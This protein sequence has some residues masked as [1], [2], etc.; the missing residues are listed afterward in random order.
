MHIG[1][2]FPVLCFVL[3]GLNA[4]LWLLAPALRAG[5]SALFERPPPGRHAQVTFGVQELLVFFDPWLALGLFPL[6][7]TVGFVALGLLF[8]PSRHQATRSSVLTA[9]L[10]PW[11]VLAFEMVWLALLVIGV[12]CRGPNWNFFW[13][14]EDWDPHL[15]VPMNNVN[16]SDYFWLGIIREPIEGMPWLMR[17]A[18]GLILTGVYVL[19]GLLLAFTM[20]LDRGQLVAVG[21]FLLLG[22]AWLAFFWPIA[23]LVPLAGLLFVAVYLLGRWLK[24]T[25]PARP[26]SSLPLWRWLLLVLLVL[27]AAVVPIKVLMRLVFNLKYFIYLPEFP[28]NV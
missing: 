5:A 6:V 17:E 25:L 10:L 15:L 21:G 2:G 18:P 12:A 28:L 16:L 8:T 14:W 11:L 26:G 9:R 3:G 22:A 23:L 1:R 27:A 20:W 13:P 19:C 24:W 4:L 7:Y